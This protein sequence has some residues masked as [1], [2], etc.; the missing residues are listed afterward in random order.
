MPQNPTKQ[1]Y[2]YNQSEMGSQVVDELVG[3]TVS[4]SSPVGSWVEGRAWSEQR[5]NKVYSCCL[6][7]HG[8]NFLS[9]YNF[10]SITQVIPKTLSLS[11]RT[12]HKIVLMAMSLSCT[13]MRENPHNWS[14]SFILLQL[15]LLTVIMTRS[16]RMGWGCPRGVMVKA[17]DCGIVK[18]EFEL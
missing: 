11:F 10:L 9:I 4:V 15:L 1:K 7:C 12:C 2:I 14:R 6:T 5:R 13:C 8:L 18:D 3:Q 16:F 17:L